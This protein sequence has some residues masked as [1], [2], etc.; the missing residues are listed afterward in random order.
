MDADRDNLV[1]EALFRNADS[2]YSTACRLTG[3]PD[4]A[5]DLVQEAARKGFERAPALRDATKIRPWLFKILLNCAR[6]YLRRHKQWEELDDDL[7]LTETGCD[8][9]VLARAA[10][11]DVRRA[12]EKL[13]PGRRAVILLVDVEDFT[14]AEAADMLGVPAGTAASRL[15]RGRADLRDFLRAYQPR[16]AEKGGGP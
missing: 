15:A 5:E 7:H 16:I 10:A 3:R 12:L 1:A 9:P 4:V 11:Y 6:D 13:D 2:L 14:L 8:V